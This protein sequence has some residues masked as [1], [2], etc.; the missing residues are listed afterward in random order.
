MPFKM[1]EQAFKTLGLK[2]EASLIEA[3]QRFRELALIYHPDKNP[4]DEGTAHL[5]FVRI[6]AA[7]RT[8]ESYYEKQHVP[9][10][11]PP[12]KRR[13]TPRPRH[14]QNYWDLLQLKPYVDST[15]LMRDPY[16]RHCLCEY[17]SF[18]RSRGSSAPHDKANKPTQGASKESSLLIQRA[19]I[20]MLNGV[21]TAELPQRPRADD[22]AVEEERALSDLNHLMAST[23]VMFDTLM[24][25][26]LRAEQQK[27]RAD[28]WWTSR[29]GWPF[30]RSC[31]GEL[32]SF[33]QLLPLAEADFPVSDLSATLN[34]CVML[35]SEKKRYA[36]ELFRSRGYGGPEEQREAHIVMLR[37]QM[38]AWAALLGVMLAIQKDESAL[39]EESGRVAASRRLVEATLSYVNL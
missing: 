1:L 31:Q 7:F 4:G 25:Q 36:E 12:R 6:D 22:P 11:K 15:G 13:T 9:T 26:A 27:A 29:E 30:T 28:K 3:K 17:C 10:A 37:E 39:G 8:L 21:L 19:M 16:K 18:A 34:F 38:Q 33:D 23:A 20:E 5:E 24:K 14:H 32:S 35:T 2:P